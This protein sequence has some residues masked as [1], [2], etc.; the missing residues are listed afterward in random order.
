VWAPRV[1]HLA[2]IHGWGDANSRISRTKEHPFVNRCCGTHG[3][4]VQC[5]LSH[6]LQTRDGY[7]IDWAWVTII[8]EFGTWAYSSEALILKHTSCHVSSLCPVPQHDCC[9]CS[10]SSITWA[11]AFR[12]LHH[13]MQQRTCLLFICGIAVQHSNGHQEQVRSRSLHAI[14]HQCRTRAINPSNYRKSSGVKLTRR[15]HIFTSLYDIGKGIRRPKSHHAILTQA[16]D[17]IKRFN[18]VKSYLGETIQKPPK[19]PKQD[20]PSTS[21]SHRW[22]IIP[23]LCRHWMHLVVDWQDLVWS[24]I[25]LMPLI[26]C[27][28]S[29]VIACDSLNLCIPLWGAG[30]VLA[31]DM[32]SAAMASAL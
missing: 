24:A 22:A 6:Q 7:G 25:I 14:A 11:R 15:Y 29:P 5:N 8:M 2:P 23:R 9:C 31:L 32:E 27:L 26:Q 4:G 1:S 3:A 17:T 28:V 21:T 12:V 30:A 19:H 16:C 10:K 13:L 20:T 18:S